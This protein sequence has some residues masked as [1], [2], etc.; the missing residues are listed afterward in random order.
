MIYSDS[1]GLTTG[2]NP[3]LNG[4]V[5]VFGYDNGSSIKAVQDKTHIYAVKNN[6]PYQTMLVPLL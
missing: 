5:N 4:F 3:T 2:E 6:N 1:F